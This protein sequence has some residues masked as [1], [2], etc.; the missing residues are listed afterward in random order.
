M[1]PVSTMDGLLEVLLPRLVDGRT[2]EVRLQ[3]GLPAQVIEG[4]RVRNGSVQPLTRQEILAAI[5][6]MVP[7][8]VRARWAQ[9][10]PVLA[11]E[12]SAAGG[13]VAVSI[14]RDGERL[15][16]TLRASASAVATDRPV[17]EPTGPSAPA[18][19]AVPSAI[20]QE[21]APPIVASPSVMATASARVPPIERLLSAA[22]AQGASDLHL[23]VSVRP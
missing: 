16:V 2:S 11:F 18:A 9:D 23:S 4:A 6:P 1:P 8:H 10:E 7:D 21:M 20:R 15:A 13:A 17:P 3:I 19:V 22:W 5:Q 14:H 12:H